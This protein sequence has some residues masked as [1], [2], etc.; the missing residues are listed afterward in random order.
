MTRSL[1]YPGILIEEEI[2][3]AGTRRTS[4]SFTRKGH[5]GQNVQ[6]GFGIHNVHHLLRVSSVSFHGIFLSR[7]Q[8]GAI[9]NPGLSDERKG[10]GMGID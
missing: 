9:G 3:H 6:R 5:F 10:I 8:A 4:N 2:N 7:G 1:W